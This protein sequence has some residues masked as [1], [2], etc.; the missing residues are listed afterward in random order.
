M[1]SAFCHVRR[2]G[3]SLALPARANVKAESFSDPPIH[4]LATVQHIYQSL[5]FCDSSL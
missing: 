4:L 5:C 1:P 2:L 3:L